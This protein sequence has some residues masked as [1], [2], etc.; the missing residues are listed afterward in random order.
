MKRKIKILAYVHGYLPTLAAGAEVMLHQILLDLK[1]KGHDVRVVI[2]APA[3][4]SYD[5]IRIGRSSPK[6]D[7]AYA[8]WADVI[9]THLNRT[10]PALELAKKSKKPII[11]LVHNDYELDIWGV[12][13]QSTAALAVAN[14]EWVKK[15]IPSS[16]PSIVVHPPTLPEIYEVETSRE[17][18]TMINLDPNYKRGHMLWQLA[19]RL[20]N[21]Q[22]IGVK[23][24]WGISA[25]HDKELSNVT[26]IENS[27]NIQEVYKKTRILIMPSLYES[28]GRVATEAACSGIPVIAS[29]TPGLSESLSYSGVFA[30]CDNV[31]EWVKAIKFLDNK[32]NY[33][34]YSGLVKQRSKELAQK[35]HG[36]MIDFEKELIRI[37]K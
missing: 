8:R 15:S 2:P 28:W 13:D 16:I 6:T 33:N 32:E 17:A 7:L 11:H 23:G 35:F 27:P 21:K 3:G 5:G 25:V 9:I 22:F 4:P 24:G 10:A 19:E 36:Q 31:D 20:P 29:P 37:V 26:I 14:S 18:I 30:E 34:K 12:V 1:S